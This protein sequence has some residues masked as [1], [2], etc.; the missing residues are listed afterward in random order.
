MLKFRYK[1]ILCV[2]DDTGSTS[3]LLYE[4]IITKLVDI[5]C[6]KLKVKYGEQADDIFPDELAPIVGRKLLFRFLCSSYNINNNNH[7]YQVK[8]IS[9][10]ENM[11]KIFNMDSSMRYANKTL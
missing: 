4:D 2:I 9:D 7:V 3:L 6:H 10:D 1:V 11:I 8:M 5:P